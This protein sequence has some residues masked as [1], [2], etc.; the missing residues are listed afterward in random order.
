MFCFCKADS[1]QS[2]SI[3]STYKLW[4]KYKTKQ[5]KK[6]QQKPK[7]KQ[8]EHSCYPWRDNQSRDVLEELDV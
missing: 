3:N 2:L 5:N 1:L 8:T 6:A 7:P 4:T